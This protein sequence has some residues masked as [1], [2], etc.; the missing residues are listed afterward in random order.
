MMEDENMRIDRAMQSSQT[1]QAQNGESVKDGRQVKEERQSRGQSTRASDTVSIKGSDLNLAQDSILARKQKARKDAMDIIGSQFKMD[2]EIDRDFEER[3]GRIAENKEKAAAALREMNSLSEE[4]AKLKEAYGI[5]D[6]SKEQQD[7][8]LRMKLEEAAD[9][10]SNVTL[11][12]EEVEQIRQLGPMT[13]YQKAVM[14]L[15]S[16]KGVWKEEIKEANKVIAVESQVIRDTK[17]E[18]LKYHGMDDA[19]RL[20]KESLDASRKEIIGMLTQE[21][22][23]KVKEDMEDTVEKAEEQQEKKEEMEALREEKKEQDQWKD[24]GMD[25]IQKVQNEVDAQMEE[26]RQRQKLLE[27]DLKGIQV[28]SS[29]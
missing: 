27:E 28:D 15:E 22:M 24:S 1:A 2:S 23:D 25:E 19:K 20:A 3:R 18:L 26:I 11:T 7:L 5:E 9:P 10:N 4:Q 8:E 21:S 13:E 12:K 6:D 14:G 17:Q 29:I 16:S